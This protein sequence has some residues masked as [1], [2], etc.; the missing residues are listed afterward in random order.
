MKKLIKFIW[1]LAAIVSIS[2]LNSCTGEF[3]EMNIDP[4]SPTNI[5]PQ[6]LLPYAIEQ[7]IDNYW[8]GTTRFQRLNIDGAMLWTQYLARNIYSNEGDSYGITP[9]FYTNNWT[10]LYNNSLVN[11]ERII[12]QSKA[13]GPMPNTNYEGIALVMKSWVFSLLTDLYGPI[14]YKEALKGTSTEPVY[15][16]GYDTQ[17]VVYAGLLAD[18]K[19]ANEKLTVGGPSVSGDILFNGDIL[20]WKKFANSLRLRLAN[21]Q[22]A[23]KSAESRAIFAEI[24]GNPAT[25]PILAS[26]SDN[27]F[28]QNTATRPSN[29]V[30]NQ[31]MVVDGRTD[32]NLSKTLVDKLTALKDTRLAV[33]GNPVGGSFSGIP[34]G[35]PDAIATTYLSSASTIGSYFTA[36]VAPSVIM[37]FAEL[38][39][40]LAEAAIDGD[41]SGSAET[42][43]KDGIAASF[44]Q[45]KATMPADYY[46]SVGPVTKANILDQKWIALFGQGIEAWTE[47]RRTGFPVMPPNDPRAVFENNGVIPTRL[48]YPTSEY[49]LNKAKLDAAIG[50]IGTDNMQSKLWWTE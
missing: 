37:T 22:A 18:L 17:E 7:S 45:F 39:L 47:Y 38:K 5:S 30:W 44:A 28:L 15:T 29:N 31:V 25:Y 16:P 34:N 41:I 12:S 35:L 36:D 26:N 27:V 42:Y 2:A 48:P 8:G 43:F 49:S 32:W 20:K 24:L 40:I 19:I 10:I 11:L 3:D 50:L 13:D 33:F 9:A 14:P 1:S 6:Y 4:N 46:T 21:R 23:K